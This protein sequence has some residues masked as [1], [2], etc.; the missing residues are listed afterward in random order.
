MD[1]IIKAAEMSQLSQNHTPAMPDLYLPYG[2][3]IHLDDPDVELD[4]EVRAKLI[5]SRKA[6]RA[7]RKEKKI[8][9]KNNGSVASNT[10]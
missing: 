1:S 9:A 4:K 6:K 10:L 8:E 5:A 7:G 3:M 2:E